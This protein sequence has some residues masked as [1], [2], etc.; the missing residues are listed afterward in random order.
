MSANDEE[1]KYWSGTVKQLK[2]LAEIDLIKSSDIGVYYENLISVSRMYKLHLENN[3]IKLFFKEIEES[4]IKKLEKI[5]INIKKLSDEIS[6][7][8]VA[9]EAFPALINALNKFTNETAI[10]KVEKGKEIKL[11]K[12]QLLRV[13]E[14]VF[15]RY[16]GGAKLSKSFLLGNEFLLAAGYCPESKSTKGLKLRKQDFDIA[17]KTLYE[18]GITDRDLFFQFG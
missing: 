10:S 2:Y 8:G 14:M 9:H 18:A 13:F 1:K 15:D 5:K 16:T 17:R 12:H 6:K 4:E 7:G 11:S 3:P